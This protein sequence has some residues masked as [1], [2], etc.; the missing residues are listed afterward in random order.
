MPLCV[1]HYHPSSMREKG[2]ILC[3]D[4][5]LPCHHLNVAGDMKIVMGGGA[6]SAILSG[7]LGIWKG[8]VCP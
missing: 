8:F 4:K 6:C 7:V 5:N 2:I 3:V 1:V